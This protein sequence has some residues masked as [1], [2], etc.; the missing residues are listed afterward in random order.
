MERFDRFEKSALVLVHGG[1]VFLR[2]A[3][4]GD[5]AHE[6]VF[7]EDERRV[8]VFRIERGRREV[9]VSFTRGSYRRAEGKVERSATGEER[10]FEERQPVG[11]DIGESYFVGPN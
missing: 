11:R 1:C 5:D 3:E 6:G 7:L 9:H 8:V 10:V 4:T 2:T